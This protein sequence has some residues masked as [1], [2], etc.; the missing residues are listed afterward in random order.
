MCRG[1]YF[2][3]VVNDALRGQVYSTYLC[4]SLVPAFVLSV[5][6]S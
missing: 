2:D 4:G 5:M 6:P 1:C 3:D